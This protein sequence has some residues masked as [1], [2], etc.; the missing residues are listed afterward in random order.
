M[1]EHSLNEIM[2]HVR[3]R[4]AKPEDASILAKVHVDSWQVAYQGIVPDTFLQGFTY[5]RREKAFREAL[6][7]NSE[8]TYLAED[9]QGAVGILTI[10]PC[11]DTDLDME[12]TGELWGIYLSPDYWRRGIGTYLASEAERLLKLR[13]YTAIVLWVLEANVAARRFYEALG[14]VVDGQLK[15]VVLGEPLLAVRYRKSLEHLAREDNQA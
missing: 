13:G 10:G 14:F 12:L 2:R 3:I 11:R 4:R 6:I 8:E 9:S 15:T 5:A 1:G 7:A